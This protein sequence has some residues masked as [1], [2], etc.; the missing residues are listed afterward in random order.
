MQTALIF[1]AAMLGI[2]LIC[3]QLS[4]DEPASPSSDPLYTQP[5]HRSRHAGGC[6]L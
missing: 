3:G 6:N 2:W 5:V 4:A 1:S